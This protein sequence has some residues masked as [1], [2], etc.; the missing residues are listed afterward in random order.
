ML[1]D[2]QKGAILLI[3][4]ILLMVFLIIT[5][6]SNAKFVL[7]TECKVSKKQDVLYLGHVDCTSL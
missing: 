7:G 2:A 6:T 4:I 5:A 3:G 1:G